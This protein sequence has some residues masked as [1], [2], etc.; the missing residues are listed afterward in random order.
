MMA[1]APLLR[2]SLLITTS[3]ALIASS[4]GGYFALRCV[5]RATGRGV[6]RVELATVDHS[7][8]VTD[9]AGLAAV[10]VAGREGLTT[11]FSIATDGY[12]VAADGLGSRD[13]KARLVAGGNVT[14]QLTR[15]QKAERLYRLTGFGVF[16]DSVLLGIPVP[17]SQPM[18]NG[19]VLGQDSI[20]S[21]VF[22][23]KVF[24]FW[25]D[26]NHLSYPL[27]NFETS[28]ATSCAPDSE[29]CMSPEVGI[30]LT[31]FTVPDPTTG[32]EFTKKMAP[33][34]PHLGLPTWIGSVSVVPDSG[35]HAV[36]GFAMTMLY[37]KP[38]HD[39]STMAIGAA[40]WDPR[41]ENFV[42]LTN[43]SLT[44]PS[45]IGA[46]CCG[47]AVTNSAQ[48]KARG[49]P[50][51]NVITMSGTDYVVYGGQTRGVWPMAV[52]RVAATVSAIQDANQY[53]AFTPLL[54]GSTPAAPKLARDTNGTPDWKWRKGVPPMTQKMEMMLVQ[55]G[56]LKASERSTV[57]YADSG[58]ELQLAGGS[59][60]W[61]GFRK[62]YIAIIGATPGPIPDTELNGASLPPPK[63]SI[64][65]EI[66]Y[67]ES[68]ELTSGW[69]NATLI[70]THS[71]SEMSCYNPL[72]LPMY[73]DDTHGRIYITCTFVNS[74]SGVVHKQ[75]KYDYNNMFFGLD[76]ATVMSD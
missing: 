60:H 18:L 11:F 50:W 72:Q 29:A 46:G 9:S 10:E 74:F 56:A 21:V 19:G 12:E 28:G 63:P 68:D 66:F 25:G 44:N 42:Q 13:V 35:P 65:G 26:T 31:Y 6:P 73:D 41:S 22:G 39:F 2:C 20:L 37:Q 23:K 43:W 51:S 34:D 59:V 8:W 54:P 27:G 58:A 49:G 4:A 48:I 70:I 38:N 16:F 45:Q 40:V 7:V 24:W 15:T 75:Q 53:E 17:T 55:Q 64:L 52:T 5:D 14:V 57:V 1:S 76:L 69:S 3:V 32:G 62:K 61:N 71:Q 30:D 36:N 47:Q 67:A 33:F